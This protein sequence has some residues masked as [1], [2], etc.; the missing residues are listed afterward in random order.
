MNRKTGFFI[1][2][3]VFLVGLAEISMKFAAGFLPTEIYYSPPTKEGF[4]IYLNETIHPT[5][6][7][8]FKR[9]DLTPAG[10]RASPAGENFD[11]PCLSLYGDSFTYGEE[12]NRFEAWGNVLASLLGCRVDNYGVSGYGSDQAYMR[13]LHNK[14]DQA[15]WVVLTHLTENITR[16]VNQNH[17]MIYGGNILL[18]PRF[19]TNEK[20][21]L[22]RIDIPRL[23]LEDYESFVKRPEQFLK[24][25]FFLPDGDGLTQRTLGFPYLIRAPYLL[26]YKRVYMGLWAKIATPPSWYAEMYDPDH[27][28]RALQVTR[29]IIVNFAR[30]ARERGQEP[31]VFLLPLVRDMRLFRASGSWVY[32]PLLVALVR[33]KVR[34]FGL[35]EGL[36]KKVGGGELCDFFCMNK[37]RESGHFTAHGNRILGERAR[38]ILLD[39]PSFSAHLNQMAQGKS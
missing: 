3:V 25:E 13:F 1:L 36:L 30:T 14:E 22:K 26:T 37:F 11:A 4:R 18:K 10:Y 9:D 21:N 24:H 17:A 16:N 38:D 27:P 31:V 39:L 12:V 19:I 33:N 5:F 34:V 2:M 6:G 15:R 35:G 32:K 8:F 23:G 28:S 29:D 7:W 20:G